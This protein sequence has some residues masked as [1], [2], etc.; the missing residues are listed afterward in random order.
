MAKKDTEKSIYWDTMVDI[1]EEH[2]PKGKCQ[3]RGKALV[4]LAYIEMM[5]KGI[6]FGE[7]GMP[8]ADEVTGKHPKCLG[9]GRY[10]MQALECKNDITKEWDQHTYKCE[11]SPG[12]FISIG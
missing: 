10:L 4:M 3:E 7:D 1:L 2:F 11:C 9:C 6:E 5:L 8:C 12:R